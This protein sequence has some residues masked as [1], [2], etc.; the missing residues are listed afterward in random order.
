M[1]HSPLTLVAGQDPQV[2][3][4]DPGLLVSGNLTTG[5]P[6][7]P[8]SPVEVVEIIFL[9]TTGVL[10]QGLRHALPDGLRSKYGVSRR[11]FTR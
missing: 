3:L 9:F 11:M 6:C 4:L 10:L 5:P 1:A 8:T 2:Q 7:S